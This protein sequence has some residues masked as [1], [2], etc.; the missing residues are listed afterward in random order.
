MDQV[1]SAFFLVGTGSDSDSETD[2]D[3]EPASPSVDSSKSDSN[4]NI[5]IGGGSFRAGVGLEGAGTSP[6]L[7]VVRSRWLNRGGSPL[8]LP[9]KKGRLR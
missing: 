7:V 3:S 8:P 5:S 6:V 1:S 9:Y 2:S 4:S